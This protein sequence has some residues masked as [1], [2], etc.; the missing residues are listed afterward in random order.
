MESWK[1]LEDDYKLDLK[2]YVVPVP[3]KGKPPAAGRGVDA[4][5]DAE[6]ARRR[7][8]RHREAA[9]RGRRR[10]ARQGAGRQDEPRRVRGGGRRSTRSTSRASASGPKRTRCSFNLAEI[11]FYHLGNASVAADAYLAAVRMNPKGPL[12]RDALYN[13][14]AA[15]EVARAKEFEAAKTAGKKAEETPTD[16]QL[17]E[18]M[19]LYVASYPNDAKVPELLFRQGKLY[20]DY[21]VYDPAVRQWGLL[22][23]KYPNSQ[24]AVGA[25]ELIL[26]SFNKSKDYDNIE[27]WA[28]RLKTAPSFQGAGA[29][30]PARTA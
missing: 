26:D 13:A 3:E 18:A 11:Y 4:R 7:R 29:A 28:R 2:E 9:A 30:E 22:L 24:Y 15:L 19:E 6:R 1:K 27:T 25:G 12:S 8:T 23:E 5:A 16:K 21:Q 10:P 20:Y 17:T 14:L